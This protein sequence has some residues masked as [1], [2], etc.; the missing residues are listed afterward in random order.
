MTTALMVR[1]SVWFGIILAVLMIAMHRVIPLGFSQDPEV[2]AALAAALIVVALS[3]PIAGIAF[4]LDGVLIGAGD[5]RYLAI[6]GT[7]VTC[8]Y[9][10]FAVWVDL[11]DKSLVWLWAAYGISMLGRGI[12]LWVRA[13]GARWMRLGA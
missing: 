3:Q 10:P 6:A 4:I 12:A 8:A 1:W 7:I 2:R 5:A 13:R 9:L 11:A